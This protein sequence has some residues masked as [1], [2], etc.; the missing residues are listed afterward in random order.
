MR[1]CVVLLLVLLA[2]PL[3]CGTLL[4]RER[5]G[6]PRGRLDA[7][8]VLL[9]SI[10][11]VYFVV[12]GLIA[13]AVDFATGAIYLPA[14]KAASLSGEPERLR[15]RLLGD[16]SRDPRAIEQA[17]RE[18]AGVE[19]AGHWHELVIMKEGE[20]ARF[21]PL[22]QRLLELDAWARGGEEGGAGLDPA[23]EPRTEAFR[24]WSRR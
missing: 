24:S 19:L 6:Q 17:L 10:A 4:Y 15:V 16:A 1:K 2:H 8:V 13:F 22:P 5:I 21:E 11:L 3:G 14:E 18:V 7:S 23:A 12:P 20:D 9:D